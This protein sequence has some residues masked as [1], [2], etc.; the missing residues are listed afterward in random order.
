MKKFTDIIEEYYG[1]LMGLVGLGMAA[2]IIGGL[3]WSCKQEYTEEQL[4]A[5]NPARRERIED[6]RRGYYQALE[7]SYQNH[8][9]YFPNDNL[10]QSYKKKEI[11]CGV[12]PNCFF[13]IDGNYLKNKVKK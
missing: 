13:D 10:T 3:I 9:F 8:K 12:N 4:I 1:L 2:L 6:N 5:A 11:I 7:D